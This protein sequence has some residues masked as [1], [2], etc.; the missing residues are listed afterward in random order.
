MSD[1]REYGIQ[2]RCFAKDIFIIKGIYE[3]SSMCMLGIKY[4]IG[5]PRF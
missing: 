1:P 5:P 2:S 3:I 4:A